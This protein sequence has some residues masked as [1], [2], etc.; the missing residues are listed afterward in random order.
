[1]GAALFCLGSAAAAFGPKGTLEVSLANVRSRKI[2]QPL[3]RFTRRPKAAVHLA[4]STTRRFGLGRLSTRL[5][6]DSQ[7]A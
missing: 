2:L 6:A 7:H 5:G 3:S 4:I 1:M